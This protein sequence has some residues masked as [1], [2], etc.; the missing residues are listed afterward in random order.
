[1]IIL[2]GNAPSAITDDSDHDG[3]D[4]ATLQM[5]TQDNPVDSE[6]HASVGCLNM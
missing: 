1:M 2:Q 4:Q 6:T 5:L 3:F